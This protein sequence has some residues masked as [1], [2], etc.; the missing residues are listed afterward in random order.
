MTI[1]CWDNLSVTFVERTVFLIQNYFFKK[2]WKNKRQNCW[3]WTTRSIN[4]CCAYQAT[5][6]QLNLWILNRRRFTP[7][8]IPTQ[9]TVSEKGSPIMVFVQFECCM[10]GVAIAYAVYASPASE[11]ELN[12]CVWM[13]VVV[14]GERRSNCSHNVPCADVYV[15]FL[16]FF[17]F[18]SFSFCTFRLHL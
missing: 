3:C 17:C 7:A 9:I 16:F 4:V 11:A 8:S 1:R 13:C 10:R 18:E 2:I 6:W 5:K 14:A 15:I 12:V